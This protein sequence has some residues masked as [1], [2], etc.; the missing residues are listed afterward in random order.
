MKRDRSKK[1]VSNCPIINQFPTTL[2]M[3]NLQ[4]TIDA[5]IA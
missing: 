3:A 4:K 2:P 5:T 1:A